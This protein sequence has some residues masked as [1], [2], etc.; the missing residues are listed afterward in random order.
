MSFQ[1]GVSGLTAAGRNLEVIGNNVA[2]ASTVGAKVSR[3]EF[4]DIYARA[5]SG[6]ANNI[7][8]GVS[9]AAVTQQFSQGSISSTDNPLD[10]AING[11][12]FFQLKDLNGTL[13]Y[14]RNGQLQV[15]RNGYIANS[16]GSRLL[17][18][19]A[20]D[21]GTLVPGQAQPLT[22]PTSGIKPSVTGNVA[23]E[24]NLDA[25]A[26]VT[27]DPAVTPVIDFNDAK[28]YNSATS[29][30]I[31]DTKGQEVALTY[32]FQKSAPDTWS[33]YA[34]ANG[35]T[36]NPDGNGDP[37]PI[38]SFTFPSDGSAPINPDDATLPFDLVSFDVPATSNAQGAVTEPIPGIEIDL[39][40]ITQYGAIFGVT[41]VTQD[42]F[43]PGQLSTIAIQPN[44]IV[45]ATY[46]SGQ[47]TPIGQVELA[48]FRNV[49]GLRPLGGNVWGATYDSGD[50][51]L[52]TPGS[53][54]LGIIQSGA[55]EESNVD[56]TSE[57][58]NMMVAQRI[59]QANAQTIKTQDSVLQTLVNLR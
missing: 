49:Q 16:Q 39:S 36:V 27:N 42:G 48:T 52:G 57:L 51:V 24:L 9:L 14:S 17:G 13:Q 43:P 11:G 31:Y 56:L 35:V 41:N 34:A 28:T 6:G 7:G 58:V 3:A 10:L 45:L 37:L 19:P 29:V 40:S 21:Q 1:Q 30:N 26:K 53:G 23:L 8:I 25:R 5:V 33:V 54:N 47:S 32:F 2:N 50:P 44:G 46:S 59:Y 12:G 38:S 18:Y 22:L 20:N 4:A 15:D 55:V